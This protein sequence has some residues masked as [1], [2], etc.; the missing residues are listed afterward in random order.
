MSKIGTNTGDNNQ[1]EVS[2]ILYFCP[3]NIFISWF[4]RLY[5]SQYELIFVFI[6]L[7]S[8]L[9]FCLKLKSISFHCY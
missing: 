4:C 3:Y 1:D 2:V 6:V 9:N 5:H 7:F 8:E